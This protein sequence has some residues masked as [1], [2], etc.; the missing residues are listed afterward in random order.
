M[1]DY[2]VSAQCPECGIGD[3]HIIIETKRMGLFTTG[4]TLQCL[5]CE[6]TWEMTFG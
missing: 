3:S 5:L 4:Y 1:K 6:D 2:D